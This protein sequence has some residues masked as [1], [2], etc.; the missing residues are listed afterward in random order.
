MAQGII[1]STL[2]GPPDLKSG[3]PLLLFTVLKRQRRRGMEV[4]IGNIST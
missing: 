4:D 2:K 1:R 3:P